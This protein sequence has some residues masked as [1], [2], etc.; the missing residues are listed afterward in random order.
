MTKTGSKTE[1]GSFES[2]MLE[3]YEGDDPKV[4]A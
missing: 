3:V 4:V 2:Q 1:L